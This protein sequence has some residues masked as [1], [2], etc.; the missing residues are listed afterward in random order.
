MSLV[1]RTVTRCISAI[2]VF[3]Y[4]EIHSRT[5][6][7][8][9]VSIGIQDFQPLSKTNRLHSLEE[10]VVLG[11]GEHASKRLLCRVA[12]LCHAAAAGGDS[13]KRVMTP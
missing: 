5:A 4:L 13:R 6:L 3:P 8:E 12:S 7:M 1:T 10:S 11:L 9:H 2:I